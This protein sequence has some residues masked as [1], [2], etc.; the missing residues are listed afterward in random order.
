MNIGNSILKKKYHT[1][2]YSSN[3]MTKDGTGVR[4]YIDVEDIS[5]IHIDILNQMKKN[6]KSYEL[7]CGTGKKLQCFRNYKSFLRNPRV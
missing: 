4:D 7:N 6:N 1:K 5:K 3:Y 2:I